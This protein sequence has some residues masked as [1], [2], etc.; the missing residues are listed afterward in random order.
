MDGRINGS[1]DG[2]T[3]AF[4]RM[5][6]RGFEGV[7]GWL[8]LECLQIL[9]M[10]SDMGNTSDTG[11]TRYVTDLIGCIFT[12]CIHSIRMDDAEWWR[13]K[14]NTTYN[15]QCDLSC[16]ISRAKWI[17]MDINGYLV[18]LWWMMADNGE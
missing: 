18:D 17:Q 9:D 3:D 7:D 1:M 2:W 11:D 8:W 14:K 6:L 10:L 16:D 15:K 12:M 4:Q 5:I 13:S